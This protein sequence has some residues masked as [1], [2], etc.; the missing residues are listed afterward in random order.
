MRRVVNVPRLLAIRLEWQQQSVLLV[1]HLPGAMPTPIG[2]KILAPPT[3]GEETRDSKRIAFRQ[4][5]W[6]RIVARRGLNS[7]APRLLL[8]AA[9]APWSH[10]AE[11][12]GSHVEKSDAPRT[13]QTH[14]RG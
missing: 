11:L 6:S 12:A 7:G 5:G 4:Q 8:N 14:F 3:M 1:V 2:Q 10:L 9:G 13:A